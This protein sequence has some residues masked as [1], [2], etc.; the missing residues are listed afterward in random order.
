MLELGLNFEF[1][2]FKLKIFTKHASHN[3]CSSSSVYNHDTA[4]SAQITVFIGLGLVMKMVCTCKA[5]FAV[6]KSM[7]K[8]SSSSPLTKDRARSMKTHLQPLS[9]SSNR[10]LVILFSTLNYIRIGVLQPFNENFKRNK[11]TRVII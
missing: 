9:T 1:L 11:R 5:G 10:Y 2:M 7:P 8:A 6:V 4:F 3:I